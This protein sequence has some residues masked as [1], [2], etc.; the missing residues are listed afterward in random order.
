MRIFRCF[1]SV[2]L[3]CILFLLQFP[4]RAFADEE[5]VTYTQTTELVSG[6]YVLVTSVGWAPSVLVSEEGEVP[7]LSAVQPQIEGN[8]V[9]AHNDGVLT[10]TV[11]ENGVTLRDANGTYLSPAADGRNGITSGEYVWS[12]T[13]EGNA[14][15]FHGTSG[16]TPVV[17][18]KNDDLG[19]L[20]YDAEMV[21]GSPDGYSSTFTLYRRTEALPESA[22]PAETTGTVSFSPEGGEIDAARD[23]TVELFCETEGASIYYA[24]STDGEQYGEY[25]L[26]EGALLLTSGFE[27]LSI[28]AYA[29]KDGY[30][31]GAETVCVYTEQT[32]S[33][34][35][36]YFGQ[37]HS[38]CDISDG[39]GTVQEAFAYAANVEGLDFFA[40]T[41]HSNS[42]DNADSGKIGSDASAVSEKWAAGKAAADA[43]TTAQFVGIYGYEMSWPRGMGLG[44]INTFNTPGFQSWQQSGFDTYASA[45]QNYYSTLTEV[46]NSISQFNHPGTFYGDFRDFDFYSEAY[47]KVITLLEV[48]CGEELP[49]AYEY[50]NRALDK[51]WHVAP[52]NS[53]N[54]HNGHWGNA[55]SGRTVV[56]ASSLTEEGIY[57]ALRNYR[58]YATEDS[59]LSIFYSL[60]GHFMGSLLE[61]RDVGEEVH[62]RVDL[63]DPSDAVGTV[64]IIT[65]GGNAIARETLDAW[66]GTVEFDLPADYGYYYIRV[67]QPDGDIAVTAP[68]WVDGEEDA[69][70]SVFSADTCLPVQGQTLTLTLELYNREYSDLVVERIAVAIDGET[71]HTATDIS[72]LKQDAVEMISIPLT[73]TGLGHTE[74]TATVTASLGGAERIYQDTLTLSFRKSDTVTDILVDGTHGV[75]QTFAQ[76]AAL[77]ADN[78]IRVTTESNAVTAEL[79]ENSSIL[80]VPAPEIPFE[81]EFLGLVAEFVEYGGSVI[82]CG[83]ADGEA[84][85]F[86][87]AEELNR[88]LS[89]IGATMRFH[90]DT[91]VDEENNGGEESQLYLANF[92]TGSVWCQNVTADQVYRHVSGCTIDPG[93]GTWLVK[94]YSTTHSADGDGLNGTSE[95]VV[96]ACEETGFGGRVFAAGSLW[97]S[98]EAVAEPQNIWKEPFANRIILKNILGDTQVQLPLSTIAEVRGG[99]I[100]QVYR[101]RG[102]VTAGTANPYNT[103]TD[104]LYIQD[105]TGGIA[106]MPFRQ[107]G[108]SVGTPMDIVGY[109]EELDGNLVLQLISWDVLDAASYRYLPLEGNWNALMDNS[110][111]GGQLVQLEGKVVQIIRSGEKG[112]SEL[113][114]MNGNGYYA[115]IYIED[116]IFSGSTGRNTLVEE[117]AIGETARA[118][119]IL[120]MRPDGV[121]AVRVRNC[122]EVVY[123]PPLTYFWK[124]AKADN[125]RSGDTIGRFVAAMAVSGVWLFLL[126]KRRV[127]FM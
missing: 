36:L 28:K 41:D 22:L 84:E 34:W 94:G 31:P 19:F 81:A 77:A 113:I 2:L 47:D 125:P 16:E 27:T 102:Y 35:G 53:Q 86:S 5:T 26:Y 57:D 83:R 8:V 66:T 127:G 14:F 59:D 61:T 109:L 45:L 124:P 60:D 68:V 24:V 44:H 116:S 37:L 58:V 97:L 122:E 126:K 11:S 9:T 52:T 39:I 120:Y 121:S 12:V 104:T 72:P 96:L 70:I 33:D 54:N 7:C 51:G 99:E 88:L 87:A 62:I 107:E 4:G 55:D 49:A 6:E 40:V 73:Y 82:I 114:L 69:G 100:G 10:L 23:V 3:A 119:G 79:L 67:I 20:A 90:D 111:H 93:S 91:A 89:A 63:S 78:Q 92:N 101:I 17:L 21:S 112:I 103:F 43:V 106:V 29:Q 13:L 38:H 105:N 64:E 75:S 46:P 115:T 71:V 123:V 48:G 15:S 50:Y 32:A 65:D 18:A 42:F 74:I 108:I 117:I 56:W 85:D 80:L 95:T 76:L 118:T 25:I 1:L 30:L 110:L 98:D